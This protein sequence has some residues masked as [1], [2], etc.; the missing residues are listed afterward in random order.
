MNDFTQLTKQQAIT[1]CENRLWENMSYEERAKFQMVQDRLCMPFDVF[2]EA[3]SKCLGRPV[4]THEFGLNREG[5]MG[6][7]FQGARPPTLEKIINLMP[8]ENT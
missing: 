6:E 5:L 7:V 2:H 4:Y 1:F 3:I 8:K